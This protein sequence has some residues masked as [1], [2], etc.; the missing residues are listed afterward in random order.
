MKESIEQHQALQS[1]FGVY[2]AITREQRDAR[3]SFLDWCERLREDQTPIDVEGFPTS[4]TMTL[5][6]DETD[7][8]IRRV[9]IPAYSLLDTEKKEPRGIQRGR[10]IGFSTNGYT[11]AVAT[12]TNPDARIYNFSLHNIQKFECSPDPDGRYVT[13][14]GHEDG[15]YQ[16][17]F[18]EG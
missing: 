9:T 8:V 7:E 17:N 2:R 3:R 4:A 12:S 18:E 16:I 1:P 5:R 11:I 14:H 13:Y 10:V 15:S 6:D